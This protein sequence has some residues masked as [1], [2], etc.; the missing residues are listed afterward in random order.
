MTK[1]RTFNIP[2]SAKLNRILHES[3]ARVPEAAKT[4]FILMRLIQKE[5]RKGLDKAQTRS[6]HVITV[7]TERRWSKLEEREDKRRKH[8]S[9]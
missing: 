5:H 1:D 2:H 8:A 3:D 4:L 9:S 6:L 7:Q